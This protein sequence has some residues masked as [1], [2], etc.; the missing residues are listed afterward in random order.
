MAVHMLACCGHLFDIEMLLETCIC[1]ASA[2]MQAC[3][4]QLRLGWTL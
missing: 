3:L 4:A 1:N 2:Q